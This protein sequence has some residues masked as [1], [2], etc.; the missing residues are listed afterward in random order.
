MMNF[1]FIENEPNVYVPIL[2][3]LHEHSVAAG[4]DSV[5]I[6]AGPLSLL[7]NAFHDRNL[8]HVLCLEHSITCRKPCKPWSG[9]MVLLSMSPKSSIG[10]NS[11]PPTRTVLLT[12]WHEVDRIGSISPCPRHSYSDSVVALPVRSTSRHGRL[13]SPRAR[14]TKL[15]YII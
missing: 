2:Q 6:F 4:L 3:Y 12:P 11:T 9:A 8:R 5:F 13:H 7:R 14:D 1:A 10:T 15:V